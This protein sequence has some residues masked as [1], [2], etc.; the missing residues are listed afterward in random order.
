[1]IFKIFK[2]GIKRGDVY[3]VQ[4][5]DFVGQLFNFIKTEDDNYVFLSIPLMEIQKVPVEKFDFAK[6]E[7]IIEYVESLPRNIFKVIKA[8]YEILEKKNG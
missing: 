3:A 5:G 2:G 8:Q 1:M 4:A 6:K 7:G